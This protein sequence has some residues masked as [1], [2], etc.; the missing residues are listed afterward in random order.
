MMN[1]S[2][3]MFNINDFIF[4]TFRDFLFQFEAC[5]IWCFHAQFI[6]DFVLDVLIVAH[7]PR[8][9]LTEV[10]LKLTSTL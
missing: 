6:A 2:A 4:Y 7:I 1:L 8:V 3:I 10:K 5:I 9:C